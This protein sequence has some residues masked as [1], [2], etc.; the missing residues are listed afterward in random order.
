MHE[1]V[2]ETSL[3]KG[4]RIPLPY[5]LRAYHHC[6]AG[7]RSYQEATTAR[8]SRQPLKYWSDFGEERP[9]MCQ[10]KAR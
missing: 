6:S 8:T 2:L 1:A 7:R 4:K 9:S 10:Q 5:L 3:S